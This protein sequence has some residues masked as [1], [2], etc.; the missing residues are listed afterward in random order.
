MEPAKNFREKVK[1]TLPKKLKELRSRR[2]QYSERCAETNK[3][4]YTGSRE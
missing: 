4:W 1:S 3:E 2:K